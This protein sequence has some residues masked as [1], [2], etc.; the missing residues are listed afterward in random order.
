MSVDLLFT[1]FVVVL[2]FPNNQIK[3]VLPVAPHLS[4]H[5]GAL[6][7]NTAGDNTE[8]LYPKMILKFEQIFKLQ[9]DE[10]ET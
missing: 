1:F 5:G 8:L 10:D 7:L 6:G 9:R 4:L 3:L 2:A